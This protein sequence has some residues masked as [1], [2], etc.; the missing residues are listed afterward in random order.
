MLDVTDDV[1]NIEFHPDAGAGAGAGA[2]AAGAGAGAAGAGAGAEESLGFQPGA[3]G[4][5]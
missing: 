4:Y 5:I 2:G 3:P 1:L